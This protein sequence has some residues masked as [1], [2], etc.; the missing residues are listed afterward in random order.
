MKF[1]LARDEA[2]RTSIARAGDLN[3]VEVLAHSA[4]RDAECRC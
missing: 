3:Q 1:S 4:E 2:S